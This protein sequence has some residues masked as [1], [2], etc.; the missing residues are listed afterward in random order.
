MASLSLSAYALTA[1]NGTAALHMALLALGVTRGDEVVVP[2]YGFLAA[3]NVILQLGARPV[4]ADVDPDT[5]CVTAETLEPRLGDRTSA[6]V[7]I[8]T[9]GNVCLMDDI[10]ELARDRGVT[11]IEDAAEA[12]ASRIGNRWAGTIAEIGTYSFQATK[13]I[14]TGEGGM[15][16][17]NSSELHDRMVL[18]RNHGMSKTRYWHE[19]PGHN[20][21]LTNLQ[22]ALGCAQLTHL[23]RIITERKRVYG[24]YSARLNDVDGLSLQQFPDSVDPVPWSTAVV[25]DPRF[26]QRDRGDIM[27]TMSAAGIETRPGFYAPNQQ[28]LYDCPPMPI[29]DDLSARILSLPTFPALSDDDID[30]VA[31]ALIALRS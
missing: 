14:S 16:V 4:F 10:V 2:A 28:P 31:S 17:T 7:V 21:R 20:F 24:S 12:F 18:Y 26:Y 30:R 9:Y 11:V 8:H 1:A 19:V 29:S 25:L 13:T 5:W 23:E 22:A 15:V 27:T 3:A 6:V